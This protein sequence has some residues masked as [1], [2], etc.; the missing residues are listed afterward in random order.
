VQF[1]IQTN[2]YYNCSVWRPLVDVVET[3]PLVCCDTR[4][5]DDADLDVVQ[6]IM[7]DAVEEG[8]YLKRQSKHQWYWKSSQTRNDVLVMNVW[9]SNKPDKKSGE[10]TSTI[11][12]V[13]H[14]NILI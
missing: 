13:F 11:S 2:A 10:F 14:I 7:D 5:V 6:K 12:S 3:D 9:D 1:Y 8:M 4:T